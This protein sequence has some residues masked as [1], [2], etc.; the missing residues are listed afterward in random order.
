MKL[1]FEYRESY[2]NLSG[3]GLLLYITSNNYWNTEYNP[4]ESCVQKHFLCAS[5]YKDLWKAEKVEKRYT[6]SLVVARW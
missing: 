5:N 4:I 6:G 1:L 3:W 2:E